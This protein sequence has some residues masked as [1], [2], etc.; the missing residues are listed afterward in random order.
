MSVNIWER[1][2]F[3]EKQENIL[4]DLKEQEMHLQA[5]TNGILIQ[6]VDGCFNGDGCMEYTMYIVAPKL[7]NFRIKILTILFDHKTG[8]ISITSDIV[9]T[10]YDL[11]TYNKEKL[12]N[13]VNK[14]IDENE[15]RLKIENLYHQSLANI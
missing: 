13:F 8:K 4:G 11:I 6:S 14:I 9:P 15:I 10:K 5:H 12:L 7:G 2:N 1:F 3:T